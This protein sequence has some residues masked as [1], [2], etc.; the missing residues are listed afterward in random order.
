[1]GNGISTRLLGA[2]KAGLA[3]LGLPVR[4]TVVSASL[5]TPSAPLTLPVGQGVVSNDGVAMNAPT[6]FPTA[7]TPLPTSFA[8][9]LRT[10]AGAAKATITSPFHAREVLYTKEG[11]VVGPP[12][13]YIFSAFNKNKSPFSMGTASKWFAYF[14][15]LYGVM[16]TGVLNSPVN[17]ISAADDVGDSVVQFVGSSLNG[18]PEWKTEY[19]NGFTLSTFKC[20]VKDKADV[21]GLTCYAPGGTYFQ[22]V[23]ENPDHARLWGYLGGLTPQ[24]KEALFG[25]LLAGG[26]GTFAYL[27]RRNFRSGT[28]NLQDLGVSAAKVGAA[29]AGAMAFCF[30]VSREIAHPVATWMMLSGTAVM[31][32]SEYRSPIQQIP[33]AK[34]IPMKWALLFGALWAGGEAAYRSLADSAGLYQFTPHGHSTIYGN[35]SN[36]DWVINLPLLAADFGT[37][38]LL[39]APIWAR[40]S[41]LVQNSTEVALSG[42][43]RAIYGNKETANPVRKWLQG[44]LPELHPQVEDGTGTILPDYTT[45]R[46]QI[47]AFTAAEKVA[48]SKG[49]MPDGLLSAGVGHG[50]TLGAAGFLGYHGFQSLTSLMTGQSHHMV[51]DGVLT[52]LGLGAALSTTDAALR[53]GVGRQIYGRLASFL[54]HQFG[55]RGRGLFWM[56]Y[57]AVATATNLS[58]GVTSQAIKGFEINAEYLGALVKRALIN[59]W[60]NRLVFGFRTAYWPQK[61]VSTFEFFVPGF[62][63]V[64]AGIDFSAQTAQSLGMYYESVA[65]D[66]S[67]SSDP[68]HK[69]ELLSQMNAMETRVN[70]AEIHHGYDRPETLERAHAALA[71]IAK[72]K[73]VYS[74]PDTPSHDGH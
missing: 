70:D 31:L 33:G 44:A 13:Q 38:L 58:V 47:Q 22:R 37:E 65:R 55:P 52:L 12:S 5:T 42:L 34:D 63:T 25:L 17:L 39:L 4:P 36:W 32:A 73:I 23:V 1:M 56:S 59:P 35:W 9:S 14:V 46:S 72:N 20:D 71:S 64:F 43:S 7:S 40:T 6:L 66:Y 54:G 21:P 3:R 18:H 48:V 30:G 45:V 69:A 26:V 24:Q 68:A 57:T 10:F 60:V 28:N 16:K 51:A 15:L 29:T 53:D 62:F 74:I 2:G 27:N 61:A 50:L 8:S 49:Q 11:K 19:F 67:L 41:G